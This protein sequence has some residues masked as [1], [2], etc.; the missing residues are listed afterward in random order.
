MGLDQ[1]RDILYSTED[2]PLMLTD[3]IL[4]NDKYD[5]VNVA[6][7]LRF[8]LKGAELLVVHITKE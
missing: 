8:L 5:C 6:S 2:I 1:S 4:N 3:I 7:G